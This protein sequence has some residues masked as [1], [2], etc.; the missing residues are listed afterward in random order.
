MR[1]TIRGVDPKLE[2]LMRIRSVMEE[3]DMSEIINELFREY[4]E[5]HPVAEAG[6]IVNTH[7]WLTPR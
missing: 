3:R 1:M 6:F 4:L 7:S 5:R 2:K